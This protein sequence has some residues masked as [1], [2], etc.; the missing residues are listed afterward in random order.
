MV[1]LQ[2]LI[3]FFS[4]LERQFLAECQTGSG[5]GESCFLA[6]LVR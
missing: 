4:C 5:G 1:L 2:Q 3:R 6:S